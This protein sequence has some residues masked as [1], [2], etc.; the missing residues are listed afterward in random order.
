MKNKHYE[1]YSFRLNKDT[2]DNLKKIKGELS[3]NRFFLSIIQ[4]KIGDKCYF[5]GKVSFLEKH[6]II[7]KK[8][9]GDDSNNNIILLCV[10]CHKKTKNWGNKNNNIK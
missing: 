2:V 8:D 6:H 1:S 5:C 7:A 10:S 3:W 4:E 9:G